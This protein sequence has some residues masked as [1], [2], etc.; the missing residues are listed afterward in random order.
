MI[1]LFDPLP[2]IPSG[3]LITCEDS[4][5]NGRALN[6]VEQ[7]RREEGVSRSGTTEKDSLFLAHDRQNPTE[8]TV[9]RLHYRPRTGSGFRY[10]TKVNV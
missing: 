5:H 6:E 1:G 7:D 9:N 8:P 2:T 3:L 4:T 10:G